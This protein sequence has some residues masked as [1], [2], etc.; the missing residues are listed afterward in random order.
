MI[1]LP[2]LKERNHTDRPSTYLFTAPARTDPSP[3]RPGGN[4]KKRQSTENLRK[5]FKFTSKYSPHRT[6]LFSPH[7]NA[8]P[9]ALDYSTLNL[10]RQNQPAWQA[11]LVVVFLHRLFIVPNMRIF[12]LDYLMKACIDTQWLADFDQQLDE[13]RTTAGKTDGDK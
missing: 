12:S 11:L 4:D 8:A 7:I 6:A 5:S 13:Y 2:S 9:L 1:V 3:E 10:L